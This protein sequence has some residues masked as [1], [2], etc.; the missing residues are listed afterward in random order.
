MLLKKVAM[1]LKEKNI[2]FFAQDLHEF[3]ATTTERFDIVSAFQVLEHVSEPGKFI[4]CATK[5]LKP[6]GK[7]IIGVPNSNPYLYKKD[8]YHTLNLPP[9]HMGLWDKEALKNLSD[10]FG[11][12]N[13]DVKIEPLDNVLYYLLAQIGAQNI[14]LKMNQN[15]ATRFIAKCIK[16]TL[17]PLKGLFTG[18]GLLAV[19]K[20]KN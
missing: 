9:H 2:N 12:E 16:Y 15:V 3:A 10:S 19:Y 17:Q 4:S 6:N 5:L 11:L 14:Y 8:I 7:L 18:R 13:I 20:L 1:P